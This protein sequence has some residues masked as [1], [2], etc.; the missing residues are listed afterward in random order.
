MTNNIF[1]DDAYHK[2]LEYR[3]NFLYH[4]ELEYPNNY[5]FDIDNL[6]S[7]FESINN[8]KI[9][10]LNYNDNQSNKSN[11]NSFEHDLEIKQT[12]QTMN[13]KLNQS[14]FILKKFRGKKRKDPHNNKR[15]IHDAKS[16]DNII[17]NIFHRLYNNSLNYINMLLTLEKKENLKKIN[18]N[19]LKAPSKEKK[20]EFLNK[21]LKDFFSQDIS[22]KLGNKDHNKKIIE[23]IFKEN[24]K[25]NENENIAKIIK[26]LNKN[27]EDISKIYCEKDKNGYIFKDFKLL[28][29]DSRED[30]E[31]GKEQNL[32]KKTEDI[33]ENLKEYIDKIR[34]N[35]KKRTNSNV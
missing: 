26:L 33:A 34:H 28:K 14:L 12:Q 16:T 9:N 30:E 8:R 19:Y 17:T 13:N 15:P 21:T 20:I 31:N 2:E 23:S 24:E 11:Q 22:P 1:D 10:I 25:E 5:D 29:D 4:K 6:N 3:N 18:S 27:F 7:S 32:I 35:Y